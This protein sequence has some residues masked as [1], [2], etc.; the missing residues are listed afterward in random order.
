MADP[1]AD[2]EVIAMGAQFLE[3]LG[4]ADRTTLELNTLGDTDSRTA[5]REKLVAYLEG[6]KGELSEES[7]ERLQRNPMRILDSKDEKDKEK[8]PHC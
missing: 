6:R 8:Y 3:A 2:V 1:L 4:V 7:L 5:Y